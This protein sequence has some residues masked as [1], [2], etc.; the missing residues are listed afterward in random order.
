MII[1]YNLYRIT[2]PTPPPPRPP[3]PSN[4]KRE[5]EH[6]TAKPTDLL[7]DEWIDRLTD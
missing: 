7:M 5:K 4:K 3:P 6:T 2:T 1:L